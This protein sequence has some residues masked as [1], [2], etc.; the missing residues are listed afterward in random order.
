MDTVLPDQIVRNREGGMV[1][2]SG[3]LCPVRVVGTGPL[4]MTFLSS[5]LNF[6]FDLQKV[7]WGGSQDAT[8]SSTVTMHFA[9]KSVYIRVTSN[10]SYLTDLYTLIV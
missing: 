3:G 8:C 6:H 1:V 5:K 7:F 9:W 4:K 10:L 2:W